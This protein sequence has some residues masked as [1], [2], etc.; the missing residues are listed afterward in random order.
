MNLRTLWTD[1][2]Y[3]SCWFMTKDPFEEKRYMWNIYGGTPKK[4]AFLLTVKWTDLKKVLEED[5]IDTPDWAEGSKILF[6]PP[7]ISSAFPMQKTL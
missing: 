7:F 1:T 3:A 6:T 2:N 4:K 5:F